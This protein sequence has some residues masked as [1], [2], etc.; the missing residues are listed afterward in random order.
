MLIIHK[1]NNWHPRIAVVHV[2]AETRSVDDGELNLEL[3]LLKL[4]FDNL[5]FGKLVELLFVAATVVT[6][7]REFGGEKGVDER[8]LAKTRL[9]CYVQNGHI[10][11]LFPLIL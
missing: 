3:F 8:C 2:V 5:D 1:I 7:R 6:W 4:S 10:I 9:A 11:S